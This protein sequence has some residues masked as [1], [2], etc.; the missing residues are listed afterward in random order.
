MKFDFAWRAIVEKGLPLRDR[1]DAWERLQD[2]RGPYGA[3]LQQPIDYLAAPH[4]FWGHSA[5]ATI[6]QELARANGEAR[7]RGAAS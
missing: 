1:E 6:D 4:G 5:E 7:H 3:R 2:L